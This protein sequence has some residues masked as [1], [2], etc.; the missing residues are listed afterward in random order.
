MTSWGRLELWYNS[1]IVAD[2]LGSTD[3]ECLACQQNNIYGPP[4]MVQYL[5]DDQQSEEHSIVENADMLEIEDR[6]QNQFMSGFRPALRL[7]E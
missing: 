4:S 2:R 5:M 6:L 1:V 3:D 7:Q